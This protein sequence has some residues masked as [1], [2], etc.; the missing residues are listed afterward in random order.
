MAVWKAT[1]RFCMLYTSPQ[2]RANQ[3]SPSP[4]GRLEAGEVFTRSAGVLVHRMAAPLGC[5]RRR[6]DL[7]LPGGAGRKPSRQRVTVQDDLWSRPTH[8]PPWIFWRQ[9][10]TTLPLAKGWSGRWRRESKNS[11]NTP[12]PRTVAG[13]QISSPGEPQCEDRANVA[14]ITGQ[15]SRKRAG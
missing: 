1:C 10:W 9:R 2:I 12:N 15:N 6:S 8:A 4:R 5:I 11:R 14:R 7:D 13:E 3:P